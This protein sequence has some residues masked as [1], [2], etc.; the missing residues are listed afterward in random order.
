MLRSSVSVSPARSVCSAIQSARSPVTETSPEKAQ[1]CST[2]QLIVKPVRLVS[3]RIRR[4]VPSARIAPMRRLR[5][6]PAEL[7]GS[8]GSPC[9]MTAGARKLSTRSRQPPASQRTR[10]RVAASSCRVRLTRRSVSTRRTQPLFVF[11]TKLRRSS[12]ARMSSTRRCSATPHSPRSSFSPSADRERLF[13]SMTLQ[14]VS[15]FLA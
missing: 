11:Q 6:L 8:L 9:A 1:R 5:S 7:R 2:A 10:S 14:I 4:S 15:W 13:A 3:C 12:P